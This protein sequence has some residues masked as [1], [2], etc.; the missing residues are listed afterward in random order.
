MLVEENANVTKKIL[1]L[2]PYEFK[3]FVQNKIKVYKISETI[4]PVEKEELR[5]EE[6]NQINNFKVNIE[7]DFTQVVVK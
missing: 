7:F 4:K 6:K 1:G 5:R 2:L 3:D